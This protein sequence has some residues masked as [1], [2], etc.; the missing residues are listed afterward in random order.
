MRVVIIGAGIGGLACGVRL[1]AQ[2]YAVTILEKNDTVG[3]R[4]N[5]YSA[6]GFTFDTGP[7]LLMMPDTLE[8]L[9]QDVGRE[10]FDYLSLQRLDPAYQLLFSDGRLLDFTQRLRALEAE[11]RRF[12]PDQIAPLYAFLGHAEWLYRASRERFVDQPLDRLGDWLRPSALAAAWRARPW[13]SMHAL[14]SR[15]FR[16]PYLRMAFSFQAL[17]LGI[18]PLECPAIYSLLPYLD[19]VDGVYY[20]VGGMAQIGQALARLFI[21]LGGTIHCQAEAERILVERGRVQGVLLH[22]ERSLPA[23]IV[24]SNVDLPTTYARLLRHQPPSLAGWRVRHMRKSCSAAVFLWGLNRQYPNLRHH[25]FYL[26]MAYRRALNQLFDE[27]RI[28][29][30]PAF[31][32]CAPTQTDPS[33]APPGC[34]SVMVLVPVPNETTPQD[35]PRQLPMLRE[36]LLALLDRTWLPGVAEHI[37]V[38]QMLAPSWYGQRYALADASAFGLS[39]TFW[40]SAMFR[41]QRRSPDVRGLYFVG[42][43]AHPGNGVPIVLIGARLAAEAIMEDAG[44]AQHASGSFA[45]DRRRT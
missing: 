21:E 31:Y 1:A 4:A 32:L 36:R 5:R 35:W 6:G 38:E 30:E 18:S 40:Q 8:T 15:Y 7:T 13:L 20:P 42:A 45:G 25:N 17:Y 43:G 37:T 19:L 27:E 16:S 34:E 24:V 10:R 26:P 41:P 2:G 3:G 9:F 28:P 44:D 14:A 12:G 23:E 29:D 22:D 39:P 11:V 33:M